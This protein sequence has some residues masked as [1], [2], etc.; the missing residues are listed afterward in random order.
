MT[1]FEERKAITKIKRT[2]Y[3]H[4]GGVDG[5]VYLPGE[6]LFVQAKLYTGPISKQ[7]V[8]NFKAL[9]K[10]RRARVGKGLFIHTGK[11]SQPIKNLVFQSDEI[12]MISGV[13]KLLALL[14]GDP[15]CIFGQSI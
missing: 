4:D 13:K 10:K 15:I 9:L 3:S 1:C 6:T 14:D 12:E 7:H 5:V 8:L 11:T 2:P